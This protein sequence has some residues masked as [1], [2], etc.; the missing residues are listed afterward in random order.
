MFALDERQQ[1]MARKDQLEQLISNKKEIIMIPVSEWTD[2]L[3]NYDQHSG[4]NGSDLFERE[5]E[6]SILELLEYE[7]EKINEAISRYDQGL[8]Q[9]CSICGQPIEPERIRRLVNT[10]VC[11]K[12]AHLYDSAYQAHNEIP[13]TVGHMSDLGET[14]QVAGYELFE[15]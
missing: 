8:G 3:S 2:E 10:T 7:L 14:F 15:E 6:I 4:D 5:K 1:L 9:I 12:C 11:S 13:L